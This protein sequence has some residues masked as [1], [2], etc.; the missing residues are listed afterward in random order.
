VTSDKKSFQFSVISFQLS[1]KATTFLLK[2]EYSNLKTSSG[3]SLVT[4]HLS[5]PLS[6][7]QLFELMLPVW[8]ALTVVLSA[9]VLA[10]ARRRGFNATAVTLWTLGTLFFPLVIMPLYLIAR[11][12][13][14]RREK[15]SA[16]ETKAS[17]ETEASS[18]AENQACDDGPLQ[19][20]LRR[21]LPLLYLLVMLMLGALYFYMDWQSVDAHLARANQA[22]VREQREQVMAEYRAA[23]RLEDD[24]HTHNL[25]AQELKVAGRPNEALAEFRTAQRMGEEDDELS[26]N[27]AMLLEELK[28]PM[29][30]R[31]EYERFANSALCAE[32]PHD[33]RCVA[34]NVRLKELEQG[35]LR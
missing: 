5:L 32:V 3:L 28:R 26:Y 22:R 1:L 33:V 18:D 12:F 13:M 14:R 9:W 17:V 16:V 35:K 15:E 20:P 4:R 30:T 21:T 6:A 10:S 7:G 29:E 27:I 19:L 8:F 24:A 34:A 11:A 23:L 2:T 25:L 31:P